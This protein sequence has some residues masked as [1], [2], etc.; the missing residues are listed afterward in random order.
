MESRLLVS[1]PP[2]S[3]NWSEQAS[4]LV[5]EPRIDLRNEIP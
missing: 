2:K 1:N 4:A 5:E 3:F